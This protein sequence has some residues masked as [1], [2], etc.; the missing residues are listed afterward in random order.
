VVLSVDAFLLPHGITHDHD[1]VGVM[2]NP[3]ADGIGQSWLADLEMPSI[4]IKLR[5]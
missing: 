1:R 4:N 2:D 3:V 5:T